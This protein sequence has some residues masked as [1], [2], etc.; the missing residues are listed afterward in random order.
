MRSRLGRP[1]A[2]PAVL[3]RAKE[4]LASGKRASGIWYRGDDFAVR[5]SGPRPFSLVLL[6]A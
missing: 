4:L 3:E 2:A 5:K 6:L 1:G